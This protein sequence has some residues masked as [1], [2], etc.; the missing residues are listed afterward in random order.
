ML[1]LKLILASIFFLFVSTYAQPK[2]LDEK[3][4]FLYYWKAGNFFFDK[5]LFIDYLQIFN[6]SEYN[7]YK[8]DEFRYNKF[9]EKAKLELQNQISELNFN[10]RYIATRTISFGKYDFDRNSFPLEI[11]FNNI[12]GELCQINLSQINRKILTARGYNAFYIN[13][14][15]QLN[16]NDASNLIKK[17][18]SNNRNVLAKIEYSIMN[19]PPLFERG[20]LR[21]L[22]PYEYIDYWN[23]RVYIHKISIYDGATLLQTI[24]PDLEYYDKINGAKLKDG[25]DTIY[26]DLKGIVTNSMKNAGSY[27]IVNYSN[28]KIDGPVKGFYL[29]GKL[30][31]EAFYGDYSPDKELLHGI[32]KDYYEDGSKYSE[33]E[34]NN[35]IK[36]GKQILWYNN[37]LK[38]EESRYKNNENDGCYFKWDENGNCIEGKKVGEK[39]YSLRYVDNRSTGPF[40]K[41]CECI[42]QYSSF[43]RNDEPFSDSIRNKKANAKK[44]DSFGYYNNYYSN[45]D[46]IQFGGVLFY[47]SNIA[48]VSRTEYYGKYEFENSILKV[49]END[50]L[51]VFLTVNGFNRVKKE[52][53]YIYSLCTTLEDGEIIYQAENIKS[54]N[55][56]NPF[57]FE[58]K[59]NTPVLNQGIKT[60]PIF[61][62]FMIKDL[63]SDAIIQGYI[64]S[65]LASQF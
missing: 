50:Y 62:N 63:E 31:Y 20:Y 42:P 60:L 65:E 43:E 46:Y 23:L 17:I 15:L 36:N 5:S 19:K 24:L 27:A 25:I 21:Y 11:N 8:N 48:R 39:Y 51:Q 53:R 64:K 35:G 16:E 61:I 3:T 37:G 33:T 29:S 44:S 6:S 41:V 4:A 26:Y 22:L 58:F 13:N 40:D 9:Y 12:A 49:S 54:L 34:Y 55:L 32:Y 10:T 56:N 59:Y 38:K 45:G 14:E 1:K 7:L 18:G 47:K 57:L 28:G 52:Y 2:K 30:M